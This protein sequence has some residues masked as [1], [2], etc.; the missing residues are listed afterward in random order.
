V[1]V[2]KVEVNGNIIDVYGNIKSVEDAEKLKEVLNN[3]SSNS[4]V[5]VV[6][7]SFV[8]PSSVIG[9]LFAIHDEG[10]QLLIRVKEESLYDLFKELGLDKLFRIEKI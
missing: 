8:M 4:I 3:I 10:K 6:H 5:L 2:I 9:P 1:N 7:D